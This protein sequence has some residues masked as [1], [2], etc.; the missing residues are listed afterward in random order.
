MFDTAF[1]GLRHSQLDHIVEEH[2]CNTCAFLSAVL[3]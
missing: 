3:T 1:D 2:D